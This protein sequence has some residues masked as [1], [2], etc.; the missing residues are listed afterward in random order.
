M[1]KACARFVDKVAV[2]T[3]GGGNIGASIAARLAREGARVA[4][5]DVDGDAAS[6]TAAAMGQL[7]AGHMAAAADLRRRGDVE[8]AIGAVVAELGRVDVL[9]NSLG[10]GGRRDF[11]EITDAE[12]ERV[13]GTNLFAPFL[14][15]QVVARHWLGTGSSGSI[16]NIASVE[17]AMPFPRQVHYAASKG[18]VLMLTKALALDLAP[19]GIRVNAVGPGTVPPAAAAE[20]PSEEYRGQY[21]LGRLG[22][23]A[24]VASA[25]AYLASDDADWVTGQVLYVDG[26][27]LVR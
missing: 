25:V 24:D 16:V 3:G 27:W 20:F 21:P 19:H 22:T 15:S 7:G 11:L 1:E 9:V 10:V 12:W 18:G 4:V 26:G 8:S 2:V 6:R 23:P 5:I 17:S 13:L 14:C